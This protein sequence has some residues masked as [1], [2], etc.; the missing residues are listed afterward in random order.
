MWWQS[1]ASEQK[2]LLKSELFLWRMRTKTHH[3]FLVGV[4]VWDSGPYTCEVESDLEE[5]IAVTHHLQVL[6][7]EDSY[8]QKQ[9]LILSFT[10]LKGKMH[11]L[12]VPHTLNEGNWTQK[13][14]LKVLKVGYFLQDIKNNLTQLSLLSMFCMCILN[15]LHEH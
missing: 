6:G 4:T 12:H 10:Y 1:K 5:P 8:V 15:R 7:K 9:N 14:I 11:P 3:F 13:I 2:F